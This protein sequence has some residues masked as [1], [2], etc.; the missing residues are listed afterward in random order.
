MVE[1]TTGVRKGGGLPSVHRNMSRHQVLCLMVLQVQGEEEQEEDG[2]NHHFE[3]QAR[4]S[5]NLLVLP[6]H[7]F[8]VHG[9]RKRG[10]R[11]NDGW[12]DS[13]HA[14]G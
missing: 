4:V 10:N 11:Q 14:K 5:L 1:F 12:T 8:A 2:K 7:R 9:G 13:M 3:N 6:L